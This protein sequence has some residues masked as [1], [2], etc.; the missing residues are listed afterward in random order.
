MNSKRCFKCLCVKPLDDFYAH[1][2]MK[3]GRLNKCKECAKRDVTEH[4]IANIERF[5]QY[6]VMRASMPHRVAARKEYQQTPE[7]RAAVAKARKVSRIRFPEKIAARN[8]LS[9]AV[10]DG[11]V[12]PWPVCAVP[13][14][15][16]KPEGHHP[17]YSQPLSVVW[18]CNSH[19]REVHA[20]A[21]T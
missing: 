16:G 7:G 20:I 13:E 4:R 1:A 14:C 2:A 17:D 10:R 8:K 21:A 6:D 11:R 5:R 9:N 15:A 3:D 18:L 19:H 12:T